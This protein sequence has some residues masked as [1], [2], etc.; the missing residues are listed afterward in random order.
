[1]SFMARNKSIPQHVGIIM[2]GN[3]RWARARG[4]PI[5]AGH[6]KGYDQAVKIAEYAFDRGIKY[7][8]L[9]TFSTE[10]WKR[11]AYEVSFLMNLLL[12]M[13]ETEAMRLHKKGVR[14]KFI[15]SRRRL[16]TKVL[17]AMERAQKLTHANTKGTLLVALNY[18]GRSEIL[19]AVQSLVSE[20]AAARKITEQSLRKH[21]ATAAVPD[22]DLIIRT[23]GEQ[24]LSGFLLW[25]AAYSELYFTSVLWPAF[26]IRDFDKALAEYAK[27][28]R[29]FGS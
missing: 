2:D 18:G 14:I 12:R 15:G 3:R 4:L 10:N 17:S 7:L 6:R 21:M 1:M 5:I 25:E 27:R 28:K 11:S 19:E 22:P 20:H 16:S 29:R 13:I 9:F 24:R 8:T 26:G 23:S